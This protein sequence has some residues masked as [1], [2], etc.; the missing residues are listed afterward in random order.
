MNSIFE[1]TNE[2]FYDFVAE[3][4]A[5]DDRDLDRLAILLANH[6]ILEQPAL[7]Y[8]ERDNRGPHRATVTASREYCNELLIG[9]D[10]VFE[11]HFRLKKAVFSALCSWLRT[12]TEA[13]ES[14]QQSLEQKVMVFLWICA[15]DETQRN[16]AHKFK[17]GQATV[18][19]I[20]QSLLEP[21]RKLHLAFVKQPPATYISPEVVFNKKGSGFEGAIGAVDGTHIPAFIPRAN[22]QRFWSRKNNI[23][24]NILAAV[25]F[26]GLFC[27]VLAGAEGSIHD[28]S[29]LLQ[30]VTRSFKVPPGRY[31]LA[32]AGFGSRKGIVIPYPRVRYHLKDWGDASQRPQ[33][34]KELFNLR[35]AMLRV[36]V[37]NVFGRC[38][39]KWKII[40]TSAPEY[41]FVDQILFVYAVTG[42]YNFVLLGGKTPDESYRENEL[43]LTTRDQLVL[44]QARDKADA[45]ITDLSGLQTRGYIAERAWASYQQYINIRNSSRSSE[46]G[47]DDNNNEEIEG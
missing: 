41:D 39:R 46:A 34:E 8:P 37:E 28:A 9:S 5:R 27:Y 40:R 33:N 10:K 12:N 45:T 43:A 3:E 23:S 14:R 2:E 22:Q 4:D 6:S 44:L 15:F 7:T 42:L 17:I 30:A 1:A 47:G 13:S 25:T 26:D 29:L 38:K 36:I 20:V 21:M 18:S 19:R 32:D 16:A 11:E 31:Y 35:H 24:Q